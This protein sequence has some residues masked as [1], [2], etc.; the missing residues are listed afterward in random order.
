[1]HPD[2]GLVG[3]SFAAAVA[4]D[5]LDEEDMHFG[6][7]VAPPHLVSCF[8]AQAGVKKK[9]NVGFQPVNGQLHGYD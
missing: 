6:N 5:R 1:M 4:K 9:G 3:S 2:L 8:I 7:F